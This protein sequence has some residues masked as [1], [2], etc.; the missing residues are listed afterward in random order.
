MAFLQYT[1]QNIIPW[2]VAYIIV[3]GRVDHSSTPDPDIGMLGEYTLII[4]AGI[5]FC[6]DLLFR[7]TPNTLWISINIGFLF[8]WTPKQ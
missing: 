7:K 6:Q 1:W 4:T 3:L 5:F 2:V 8:R